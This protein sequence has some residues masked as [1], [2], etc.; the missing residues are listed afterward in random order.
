MKVHHLLLTKAWV[1][2]KPYEK[3]WTRLQQLKKGD[4]LP[5]AGS[6][7]ISDNCNTFFICKA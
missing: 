2:T 1:D 7:T 3:V 5:Q 4:L 6:A